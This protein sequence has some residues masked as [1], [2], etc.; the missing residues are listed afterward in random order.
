MRDKDTPQEQF[1]RHADR[2]C[3]ILAEEALAILCEPKQVQTPCANFAGIALPE[4][5]PICAV[6]IM[7]SGDIL[8]NAGIVFMM[9]MLIV[10]EW[11]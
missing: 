7:R 10:E 1:V 8:L 3:T 5:T 6:S 2:Y 4:N 9:H 11:Q